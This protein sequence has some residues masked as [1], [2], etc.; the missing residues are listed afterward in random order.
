M[1]ASVVNFVLWEADSGNDLV[2]DNYD[3]ENLNFYL[4]SVDVILVETM[5]SLLLIFAKEVA[6]N[7]EVFDSAPPVVLAVLPPHAAYCLL[8]LHKHGGALAEFHEAL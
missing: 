2:R 4:N 6:G 3:A 8:C 1:G 7:M 5:L